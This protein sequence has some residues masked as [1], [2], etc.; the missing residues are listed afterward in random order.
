M[1][2][3][4]PSH[5]EHTRWQHTERLLF[6]GS[7]G[8]KPFWESSTRKSRRY[9][10]EGANNHTKRKTQTHT[11]IRVGFW[12][13]EKWSVGFFLRVKLWVS[14]GRETRWFFWRVKRRSVWHHWR[15]E[16]GDQSSTVGERRQPHHKNLREARLHL[17]EHN[18]SRIRSCFHD[19]LFTEWSLLK[20]SLK[21]SSLRSSRWSPPSSLDTGFSLRISTR[22][23]LQKYSPDFS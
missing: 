10:K 21:K 3:H 15:G 17:Q 1:G 14:K 12:E 6:L 7:K 13:G 4:F 18:N 22:S 5:L 20:I 19:L 11:A 9:F 2:C 8:R 16:K 23:R